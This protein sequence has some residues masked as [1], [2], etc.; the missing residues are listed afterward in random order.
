MT[1]NQLLRLPLFVKLP[2]SL[3]SIGIIIIFAHTAQHLLVPMLIALLIAILLN[4]LYHFISNKLF[5]PRILAIFITVLIFISLFLG[6]LFFISWQISGVVQD[7]EKI[8]LNLSIHH[9]NL[10]F[11]LRDT[12]G[13]S[14]KDQSLYFEST[15]GN[16]LNGENQIMGST[17]SFFSTSIFNAVLIPIYVFLILLYQDLFTKFLFKMVKNKSHHILEDILRNVNIILKSYILGLLIQMFI[18]AILTSAGMFVLG[19]EYAILI[20][21]ITALLNLIPYIGIMMAIT[22]ALLAALINSS[23]I[24]VMFG[25]VAIYALVQF[26]DNNILVPRIV[27]NKVKIN[28]LASIVGVITGGAIAGV[29]GMF[30]AIPFLAI[31]KVIFDRIEAMS[32]WGYLIGDDQNLDYSWP[33]LQIEKII[34][35]TGA[36][37]LL[38]PLP[39]DNL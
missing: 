25:V 7:S 4:P 8:I 15:L 2:L 21:V 6:I 32:P 18:V 19:V 34:A 38:K 36:V 37:K 10:R 22:I 30:L 11:W 14:L 33:I 3:L 1:D 28:A 12:I 5:V 39:K 35:K 16:T 27:G 26:I 31:I 20:G 24:S 13:F 17:L 29:A 9:D 23:E